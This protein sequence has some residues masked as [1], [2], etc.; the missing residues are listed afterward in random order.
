FSGPEW[1]DRDFKL[2]LYG[3][4]T[5]ENYLK[6]L[7]NFYNLGDKIEVVGHVPDIRQV[8]AENHIMVL[9][10][11]A[12]GSPLS[13]IEAMYCSRPIIATDVAGNT[14]LF[15]EKSGFVISGI[16]LKSVG[17]TLNKAWEE[18]NNWEEMGLQARNHIRSIHDRNSHEKI[19]SIISAS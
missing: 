14:A 10:S 6:E 15:N 16:N 11:S 12:E 19:F 7:I 13:I 8:W 9:P 1:K 5:G 2:N 17:K 4:G 3:K 18:R